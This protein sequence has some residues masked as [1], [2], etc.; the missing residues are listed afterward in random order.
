[1]IFGDAFR[2]A[3]IFDCQIRT[4]LIKSIGTAFLR[5][6]FLN[7]GIS[8]ATEKMVNA[9]QRST[10]LAAGT[11]FLVSLLVS[12][13]SACTCSHHQRTNEQPAASCHS[14]VEEQSA[15]TTQA[16]ETV[17][18]R[19][20]SGECRCLQPAPKA[21]VKSEKEQPRV[22]ALCTASCL[23][24]TP[25]PLNIGVVFPTFVDTP[26]FGSGHFHNLS[27]GRAP[28]RL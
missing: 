10:R 19:I 15:I 12:T 16:D 28:P 11:L 18:P 13:V 2:K 7:R 4:F 6:D 25:R 23:V 17:A 5:L 21:V 24:E 22:K 14:P 26:V 3:G 27:P 1:M 9:K 8:W 20:S